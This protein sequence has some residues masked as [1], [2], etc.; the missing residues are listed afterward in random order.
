MFRMLG[1][2]KIIFLLFCPF[3]S[4]T[5]DWDKYFNDKILP[6][7]SIEVYYR[8]KNKDGYDYLEFKGVTYINSNLTTLSAVIRD[9]ENMKKWVYNVEYA[10]STLISDRERYT[11]IIHKSIGFIFK[12]RDSYVHSL[13][14]Q[15]P[16]SLEVTIKGTSSPN[17]YPK[18]DKYIRIQEGES[19]W[20]FIPISKHRSKVVFQGYANPGGWVSSPF[21]TPMA[22]RELWKLPYYTLKGLKTQ[23]I[24]SKYKKIEYSFITNF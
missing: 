24:E 13:I 8:Y 7:D 11:Y 17:D 14:S 4:S 15:N 16:Y 21:L 6:H 2:V 10:K 9:V 5:Q 22:K 19:T 23:V 20:K 1:S 18:A 3:I 12:Q